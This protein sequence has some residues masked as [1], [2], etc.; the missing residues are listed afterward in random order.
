MPERRVPRA[1]SLAWGSGQII[2][3]TA[4]EGGLHASALQLLSYERGERMGQHAVRFAAYG[5][6][7]EMERRPLIINGRELGPLKREID[8]SPR[9]KALLRRLGE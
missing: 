2:E 5:Q 3:E 8:L 4:I 9:I 7:G 6:A 1:F